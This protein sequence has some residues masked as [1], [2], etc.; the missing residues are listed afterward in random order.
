MRYAVIKHGGKQYRIGEGETIEFDKMPAK[1]GD[2]VEFDQ[3]LM[4][5]KDDDFAIGEP[6]VAQAK[7]LGEVVKHG[8][9]DK[10]IVLKFRRRKHHMKRIGHRQNYTAVKIK[11]IKN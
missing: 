9:Q 5:A 2:N 3:V 10:I 1:V 7:V 8:R 11:E 4:I 6:L